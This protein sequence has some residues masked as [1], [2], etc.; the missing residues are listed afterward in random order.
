LAEAAKSSG[1]MSVSSKT[2]RL[3][4]YVAKQHVSCVNSHAASHIFGRRLKILTTAGP[5][6]RSY[7]LRKIPLNPPHGDGGNGLPS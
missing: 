1:R 6:L 4:K 5:S 3:T 2:R 7:A